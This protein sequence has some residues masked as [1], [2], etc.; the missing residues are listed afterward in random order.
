[1]VERRTRRRGESRH[2]G[3]SWRGLISFHFRVALYYWHRYGRH[4]ST[5]HT[6]L[7][8][9]LTLHLESLKISIVYETIFI[10]SLNN[11][12]FIA[13]H[14]LFFNLCKDRNSLSNIL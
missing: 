5:T 11:F 14:A 8:M 10:N 6:N 13:G 2:P 12:A 4:R 3:D 1:M 9:E 7:L